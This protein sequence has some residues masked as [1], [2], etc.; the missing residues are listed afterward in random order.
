MLK[1][2]AAFSVVRNGKKGLLSK[3]KR[4]VLFTSQEGRRVRDIFLVGDYIHLHLSGKSI[5]A[6]ISADSTQAARKAGQG[7]FFS[8]WK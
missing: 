7:L 4:K 1:I 2:N 6:F 5:F 8:E 3:V